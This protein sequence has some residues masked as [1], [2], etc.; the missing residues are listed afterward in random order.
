MKAPL[1]WPA[2]DRKQGERFRRP[3]GALVRTGTV[4]GEMGGLCFGR[5][6]FGGL[7]CSG[8]LWNVSQRFS[9]TEECGI[10]CEWVCV[11]W[12]S[13]K[14]SCVMLH[15]TDVSWAIKRVCTQKTAALESRAVLCFPQ[16]FLCVF[17][18]LPFTSVVLPHE[19][20]GGQRFFYSR[21]AFA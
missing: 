18:T 5:P 4:L 15:F 9:S 11:R 16:F 2:E 6:V 8:C 14:I 19:T 12:R 10:P 13:H 7:T 1:C 21:K 3:S 17:W 20:S